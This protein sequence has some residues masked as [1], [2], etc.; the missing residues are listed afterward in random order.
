MKQKGSQLIQPISTT[1][2]RDA[3]QSIIKCVQKGHFKEE[4][5]SLEVTKNLEQGTSSGPRPSCV[6]KSSSVFSL[7]TVLNDGVLRVGGR[8]HR[9]SLPQDAKHQIILRKNHS[10]TNLIVRHY[11][12]MSQ[13]ENTFCPCCEA[14]SGLFM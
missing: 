12:L 9:A 1:E 13:E 5:E 3:E 4:I 10:V 7:D 2:M 11:H 8:L 6:E 14:S